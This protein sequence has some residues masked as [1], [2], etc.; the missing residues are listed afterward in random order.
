MLPS[1][2]DED[3]LEIEQAQIS[4]V[5]CG[6][7]ETRYTVYC[8]EDNDLDEDREMGDDEFSEVGFQADQVAK[9]EID[10]NS[11]IWNPREYFLVTLLERIKQVGR[12]WAR[13]VQV[14]DSA[15]DG[16][17]CGRPFSASSG[18]DPF[19]GGNSAAASHWTRKML[20]L[21]GK[22]L[23]TMRET[24][25]IWETFISNNGDIGYFSD[26]GTAP[27]VS[28]KRIERV[29]HG[30]HGVFDEMGGHYEK[31]SGIQ[32]ECEK[33]ERA[34]EI[35]LMVEA[36]K[37]T[38]LTILY[39][40]PVTV[41]STFFAIPAPFIMFPRNIWS[42]AGGVL[43]ITAIVYHLRF[44]VGGRLHQQ[45]WWGRLATRARAA[46]R[47]DRTNT[48]QNASGVRV[49]RRRATYPAVRGRK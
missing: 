41:V 1:P 21:L 23:R 31:L 37:N 9:C 10:A 32:A 45:P 12:E 7:S 39:I 48:V 13:I 11:P 38:E 22:L 14:V 19:V 3:Q 34:L 15:F 16:L 35:R 40:C 33:L 27:S 47:G 29:L 2:L 36:N 18:N 44:L 6:T 46:R 25:K 49:I 17:S 30:I 42:F 43:L 5:L 24:N 8:F 20:Q 4:V 28:K 26:L